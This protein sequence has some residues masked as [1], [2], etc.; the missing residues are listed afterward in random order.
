MYMGK[1]KKGSKCHNCGENLSGIMGVEYGF[2]KHVDFCNTC[3]EKKMG[4]KKE[5][6][7]HNSYDSSMS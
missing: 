6:R 4:W 3:F 7:R 1:M 5:K 2:P